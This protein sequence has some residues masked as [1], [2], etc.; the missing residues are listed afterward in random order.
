M[1]AETA[2]ERCLRGS[3]AIHKQFQEFT[4]DIEPFRDTTDGDMCKAVVRKA[5]KTVFIT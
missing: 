5:G 1:L 3:T 2:R 4:V